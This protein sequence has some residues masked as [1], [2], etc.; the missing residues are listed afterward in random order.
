MFG[1]W[2]ERPLEEVAYRVLP[3]VR[4]GH[5]LAP[6]ERRV[7]AGVAAALLADAP[8]D[9]QPE[10]VVDNVEA[11]IIRG[12]SQRAWRIRILLNVIEGLAKMQAGRRFSRLSPR[13][14]LGLVQEHLVPGRGA[15][16]LA[17]PIRH[18]VYM[19]AYGD[20]GAGMACGV[21]PVSMRRRP[22]PPRRRLEVL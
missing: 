9:V 5:A 22:P 19:G 18:I 15:W 1:V 8:V 7:V 2:S 4:P 14:Q 12:R 13:A 17:Q 10:A 16:K 21:T 20:E 11:F 3:R 6:S